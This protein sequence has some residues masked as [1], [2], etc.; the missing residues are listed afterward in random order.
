MI[1][2]PYTGAAAPF[3]KRHSA[4]AQQNDAYSEG[5]MGDHTKFPQLAG[6]WFRI[7]LIHTLKIEDF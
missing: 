6:N 3:F 2:P 5:C 4:T 7:L 1:E